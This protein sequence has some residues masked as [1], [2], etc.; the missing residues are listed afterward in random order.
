M[1]SALLENVNRKLFVYKSYTFNIYMFKLDLT[2]NN[3]QEL[4]CHKIQLTS[5]QIFQE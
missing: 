5:N 1:S 3:L 4:I 2:F